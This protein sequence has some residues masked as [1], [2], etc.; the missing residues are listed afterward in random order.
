M[1]A[2][3]N[4]QD[5]NG[6]AALHEAAINGDEVSMSFLISKRCNLLLTSNDGLTALHFASLNG[7]LRCVQLL[8]EQGVAVDITDAA[9]DTPLHY[10]VKRN[11]VHIAAFLLHSKA[12]VAIANKQGHTPLHYAVRHGAVECVVRLVEAGADIHAADRDK[13]TPYSLARD[14]DEQMRLVFKFLKKN[15]HLTGIGRHVFHDFRRL[16]AP[17]RLDTGTTQSGALLEPSVSTS[18]STTGVEKSISSSLGQTLTAKQRAAYAAITRAPPVL[19][20]PKRVLTDVNFS[21]LAEVVEVLQSEASKQSARSAYAAVLRLLLLVPDDMHVGAKV[22]HVLE[23]AMAMVL[24]ADPRKAV[25]MDTEEFLDA[26][27]KKSTPVDEA[28]RAE[29]LLA[30]ERALPQLFEER[31]VSLKTPRGGLSGKSP[32]GLQAISPRSAKSP[33]SAASSVQGSALG[34]EAGS[35]VKPPP[36]P[37]PP[38]LKRGLT[39]SNP[40]DSS[41]DGAAPAVDAAA[42]V[43]EP[44]VAP[45]APPAV[46]A[47]PPPPPMA[48]AAPRAVQQRVRMRKLNW[49]K[50]PIGLIPKTVWSN[51]R[52]AEFDV[53][54]LTED[55]QERDAKKVAHLVIIIIIIIRCF[56]CF[57]FFIRAAHLLQAVSRNAKSLTCVAQIKWAW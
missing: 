12:S 37:P 8:I 32:R 6:L 44:V 38:P 10:A 56:H 27:R 47:A 52:P 51:A 14:G 43:L 34:S 7:H 3:P 40:V 25:R 11:N 16:R 30:I 19:L 15:S 9:G 13:I 31:R 24:L 49:E 48:K 28:Q 50:V 33:R 39:R 18:T 26:L 46:K 54:A 1:G 23:Q 45:P 57:S 20:S 4:A 5:V 29:T 53:N 35:G 17:P 21:D 2:L 22:L 55:F 42:P 41:A 36:P